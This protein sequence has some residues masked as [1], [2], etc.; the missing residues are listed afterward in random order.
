MAHGAPAAARADRGIPRKERRDLK[1][2][3]MPLRG[4]KK[5]PRSKIPVDTTGDS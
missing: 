1:V 3:K 5:I 4:R 2:K